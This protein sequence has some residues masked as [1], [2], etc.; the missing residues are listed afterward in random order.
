[1]RRSACRARRGR[2]SGSRAQAG[3]DPRATLG[4]L[5]DQQRAAV[6]AGWQGFAKN[7][8]LFQ[9]VAPFDGAEERV[10]DRRQGLGREVGVKVAQVERVLA[11]LDDGDDL[12]G[13]R[14]VGGGVWFVLSLAGKG[15]PAARLR[16]DAEAVDMWV[17][18][19]FQP[20]VQ[21]ADLGPLAILQRKEG[22]VAR[23]RR[24]FQTSTRPSRRGQ[25]KTV[26][27]VE[28]LADAL[29][30]VGGDPVGGDGVDVVDDQG[31]FHPVLSQRGWRKRGR[32]VRHPRCTAPQV[33][34][35]RRSTV[36]SLRSP[37]ERS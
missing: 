33:A 16:V 27:I 36:G 22:R 31:V 15:D 26:W 30:V 32:D 29:L 10:L 13:L 5:V 20:L 3:E 14:H 18:A 12:D 17:L 25:E 8:A 24:P 37:V 35:T 23:R 2:A 21:A 11:V 9:L 4:R 34:Q 7:L 28:P 6:G 1:M 19:A